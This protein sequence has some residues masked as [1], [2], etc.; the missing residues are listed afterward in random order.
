VSLTAGTVVGTKS[1][2]DASVGE[3][4]RGKELK[5]YLEGMILKQAVAAGY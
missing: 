5:N 2:S 3:L 4:L 1:Y